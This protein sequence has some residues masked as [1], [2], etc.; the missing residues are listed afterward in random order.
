MD[1]P[2]EKLPQTGISIPIYK[3]RQELLGLGGRGGILGMV[4]L[5]PH[6]NNFPFFK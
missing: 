4:A 5:L 2:F 1:N 3:S 6:E